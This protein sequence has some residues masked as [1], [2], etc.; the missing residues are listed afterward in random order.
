MNAS[1]MCRALVFLPLI[2]MFM[3]S[4][5]LQGQQTL[6][7]PRY[8]PPD[9]VTE[10]I[11]AHYADLA[12]IE[13][14][15]QTNDEMKL[16]W[17][18]LVER[19][20][21]VA[22]ISS[23][24]RMLA[25]VPADARDAVRDTRLTGA[26]GEIAVQSVSY[27]VEELDRQ[28]AFS[29][30]EWSEA[31]ATLRDFLEWAR[32]PWTA[33]R[34]AKMEEAELKYQMLKDELPNDGPYE[35]EQAPEYDMLTG[36]GG[37]DGHASKAYGL[38]HH[39]T[40][41]VESQ[42]G[43]GLWNWPTTTYNQYKL[44][45]LQA[46]TFWSSEAAKYGRTLSGVWH[47][48]GCTHWVCQVNGEP[49]VIKEASFVPTVIDRVTSGTPPDYAGI[50]RQLEWGQ[51]YNRHIR[52][53]YGADESII[54]FIA[55]K[56]TAG[57]GIWPH[58]VGIISGGDIEGIYYALDNQYWQ[59]VPDPLANPYRNVIAHEICHLWGAPDEYYDTW[60]SCEYS[61]RGMKTYNCQ[62]FQA[63][64]GHPGYQMRGFDGLMVG[65]YT[66]GT[67]LC[68]PVHVGLI[69]ASSAVP[70]R[71]F[72]TSPVDLPFTVRNCDGGD[73]TFTTPI[74]IPVSHDYCMKVDVHAKRTVGSTDWYMSHW[75]VKRKDGSSTT[76]QN[77]GTQLP[78]SALQSSRSNP[79][80]DVIAHYTN[81]P[82]N[83]EESNTTV[84]A[85]L[86]HYNHNVSPVPCIA[87]RWR[88]KYD[89]TKVQTKIQYQRGA[90][91]ATLQPSHIVLNHPKSVDAYRWTGV[92]IHSVPGISG[93]ETIQLN[94]EYRFRII[95]VFNTV[96]G[97][98]S[99]IASVKTRPTSPAD[100]AF[101]YDIN[102]PN[103][104]TSPK[105]LP[106]MGPGI[107]P[108]TVRGAITIYG[109]TGEFSWNRP[110]ED[111]YRVT[112][113]GLTGGL[114]GMKLRVQ[115]KVRDGSDFEPVMTYQR[116]G[117]TTE[118]QATYLSA[119][120]I[121]K[122][123]IPNDG[124]YIIKVTSKINGIS[125][126]YDL[127]DMWNGNFG[128]GEYELS[129]SREMNL[130]S[131]APICATCVRLQIPRPY[132]GLVI[133]E[134]FPPPDLVI[135]T[136]PGFDP[137]IGANFNLLYIP[138][139]DE[140]FSRFDGETFSGTQNPLPIGITPNTP[141]GAHVIIPRSTEV[142]KDRVGLVVVNPN[143]WVPPL[144]EQTMHPIGSTTTATATPAAGFEFIRWIGDTVAATNP[145]PVTMWKHKKLIAVFRPKPCIPEKMP[146]WVHLI[147][148]INARQG[149]VRLQF[150]MQ[151]GAGDGLEPGQDDL[152]PLPPPG[153]FD[154]RWINITGSQG[155][156]TDIRDIKPTHTYQG[157]VQTG[158]GTTPVRL[159]WGTPPL[160]SSFTMRLRIPALSVDLDMHTTSSYE[161]V[162]EGRY[163]IY[164]DVK[165]PECPPPTEQPDVNITTEQMEPDDYPCV[166]LELLI[167]HRQTGAP[168]PYYNPYRLKIYE[169]TK[170]GAFVPVQISRILQRDSTLLLRICPDEENDDPE[171]EIIVI[172]DEDD[173]NK[174]PDTTDVTIPNYIPDP[175]NEL[176]RFTRRNSGDWEMVSLPVKMLSSVISS[177]YPDP[178]TQLY[179]FNTSVGGYEGVPE[180]LFGEG[181]WLKT[182]TPSTLFVGNEVTNNTLTNLSGLG[183]PYG[184]G[185]N[186][187][188]GI[189]HSVAVSAIG[190]TPAGCMKSIF[191]WNPSSGYV[192]PG[193]VEPSMGYWV[194]LDP[195]ATLTFSS[196]NPRAGGSTVYEKVAAGITTAASLRIIPGS[197]GGQILRLTTRALK[198]DEIDI[199]SLP[200]IP[201]GGL[202]DARSED[203]TLY[204]QPGESTLR[205]QHRGSVRLALTPQ[206]GML[207]ELQLLDESGRLLHTFRCDQPSTFD[208]DINGTRNVLLRFAVSKQSQLAFGLEANYPNP[209]RAGEQTLLQF[210]VDRE[211]PVLLQV[212]DL[213]GRRIATVVDDIRQPG[214]YSVAWTTTDE[215]GGILPAGLYMIRLDAGGKIQTRRCTIVR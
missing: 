45:H 16:L 38:V 121:W 91:W 109:A 189:T 143:C 6:P 212:Y 92:R 77:Y 139:P 76:Y 8:V 82:P 50:S 63:A 145:L 52:S 154:V 64:P 68:T 94:R 171:R 69:P 163:V 179:R 24:G 70:I 191:G 170:E 203:G 112:T 117:T 21:L 79:I 23:P 60:S 51:H 174:I 165:E 29:K 146:Q 74:Y 67:S 25:W 195:N 80:V 30:R 119:G 194:R 188:G 47:L 99:V 41:F 176:Y 88:S 185:W 34:L 72:R 159:S 152:P 180:M 87:L 83:F 103:S 197:S 36:E 141:A 53:T 153:T 149:S 44:L 162:D 200:E 168:L 204:L 26:T 37:F 126:M 107:E 33:E 208:I 192:V 58:A 73:R 28:E 7:T 3:L 97:S 5:Q 17:R 22:V 32:Q 10:G 133:M 46:M 178:G 11:Q 27:T 101:C 210:G 199:L 190:Q 71:R 134:P 42:S 211:G 207:R 90:T 20:A 104:Q 55:Y 150:G 40:F 105:V 115:C 147:D 39:T 173:P 184:Y 66:A 54:G 96:E 43:S 166:N 181:Y 148:V 118:Q 128:F 84:S 12:I 111:Y 151:G 15:C 183:E 48:Y 175:T 114:F 140:L 123:D 156:T 161:L 78:S 1:R 136:R 169:K 113:I 214:R 49:T 206:P 209:V 124:E 62:R 19:G 110:K 35:L 196:S 205:I 102:E 202:F 31:D 138:A 155:S 100:S 61:Y 193:T 116:V 167:K 177:L 93:D 9:I 2:G 81:S 65:N 56:Q 160:S 130:P 98:P 172:P 135:P 144:Y 95:G 120:K 85:W 13:T 132:P 186:M 106:S 187:I 198:T 182:A 201:P 86:S 122:M 4:G 157:S 108:Y 142:P 213:L 75:E 59:A 131:I 127:A 158:A 215:R 164:V 57:E 137:K 129:L 14:N 18:T 89:M 125:G